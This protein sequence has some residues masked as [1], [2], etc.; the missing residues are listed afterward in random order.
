MQDQ[1]RLFPPSGQ[2]GR[3][4]A[5]RNIPRE[6]RELQSQITSP[7]SVECYY[8]SRNQHQAFRAGTEEVE[9]TEEG[10]EAL[11]CSNE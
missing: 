11:T 6:A 10:M 1:E 4:L 8:S 5:G 9:K 2:G 7:S 3:T